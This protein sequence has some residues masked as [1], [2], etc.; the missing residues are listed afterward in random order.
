MDTQYRVGSASEPDDASEDRVAEAIGQEGTDP[1]EELG[2]TRDWITCLGA[3]VGESAF[4][5]PGDVVRWCRRLRHL[6]AGRLEALE[7]A[8]RSLPASG[9]ASSSSAMRASFFSCIGVS[10]KPGSTIETASPAPR[11]ST[12]I[13]S[14]IAT[15]AYFDAQ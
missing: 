11:S 1:V 9:S 4:D 15:S 14:E 10:M 13:A 7:G 8:Y 12:R 6:L 3:R 2:L 5:R